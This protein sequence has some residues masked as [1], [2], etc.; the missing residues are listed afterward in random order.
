MVSSPQNIR[1]VII[2]YTRLRSDNHL[3]PYRSFKLGLNNSMY[4]TLPNC[5]EAYC[6]FK[7]LLLLSIT[8]PL[9]KPNKGILFKSWYQSAFPSLLLLQPII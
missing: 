3:L 4:C 1:A 2:E 7:H 8:L 5:G 6:G 9:G